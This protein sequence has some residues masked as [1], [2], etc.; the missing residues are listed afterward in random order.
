MAEIDLMK[1]YPKSKR[2]DIINERLQVSE[3]DRKIAQQ[4]G[5]EYFDGPRR[6][7]LGGYYYNPKYILENVK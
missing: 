2:S 3:E 4:F 6:L 1:R 5:K 7:G